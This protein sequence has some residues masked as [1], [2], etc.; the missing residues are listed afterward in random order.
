VKSN[1]RN[2]LCK[3]IPLDVFRK[4]ARRIIRIDTPEDRKEVSN[5]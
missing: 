4:N 1:G 5:V 2:A 3:I